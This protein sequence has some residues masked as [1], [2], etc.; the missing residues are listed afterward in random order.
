MRQLSCGSTIQHTL[1][2]ILFQQISWMHHEKHSNSLP[3]KNEHLNKHVFFCFWCLA[4]LRGKKGKVQWAHKILFFR[5]RLFSK[6]IFHPCGIW[7]QHHNEKN[8]AVSHII[9]IKSSKM[10]SAKKCVVPF[11][12]LCGERIVGSWQD[13]VNALSTFFKLQNCPFYCLTLSLL[14]E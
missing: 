1:L 6:Q 2:S 5:Q 3:V 4:K 14:M 11:V 13:L 7:F 9:V 12:A 8:S 10:T